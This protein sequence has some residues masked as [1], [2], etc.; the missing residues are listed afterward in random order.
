M[1]RNKSNRY[2]DSSLESYRLSL[3]ADQTCKPG[4]VRGS[5][6]DVRKEIGDTLC[7]ASQKLATSVS[8]WF[9]SGMTP[10]LNKETK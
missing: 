7:R 3:D 4:F 6:N 8:K 1:I 5:S 9:R 2:S 10:P